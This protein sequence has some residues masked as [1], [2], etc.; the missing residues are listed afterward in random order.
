MGEVM[1]NL[2]TWVAFVAGLSVATERITEIVKGFIKQLAFEKDRTSEEQ[3]RAEE[4]RKATIQ[5][6]AIAIGALLSFLTYEQIRAA[7]S[8]PAETWPKIGVCLVFGAMASGGSGMWNSALDI[9]RE[10]N[11]QKQVLT[12]KLKSR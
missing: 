4:N 6:I 7:M 1:N 10:V 2:T 12:D 8:L 5:I 9:V 3:R 11:K